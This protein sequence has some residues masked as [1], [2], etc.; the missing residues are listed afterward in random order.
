MYSPY[1]CNS[2]PHLWGC[3]KLGEAFCCVLRM[4]PPTGCL[5]FGHPGI[6]FFLFRLSV[7]YLFYFL[8]YLQG[9]SNGVPS[10]V[11]LHEAGVRLQV[12][13]TEARR[14]PHR[15]TISLLHSLHTNNQKQAYTP[16]E[17]C[18]SPAHLPRFPVV[19]LFW[20]SFRAAGLSFGNDSP[21]LFSSGD[22]GLHLTAF[23]K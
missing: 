18:L 17:P 4:V 20:S 16:P 6:S 10:C 9:V 1:T 2:T 22:A 14:V 23:M 7:F 5:V 21:S 13:G 11:K 15:R 3:V 8:V 19:L 12:Q